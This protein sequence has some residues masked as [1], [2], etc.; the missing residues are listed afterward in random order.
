MGCQN[1]LLVWGVCPG[2]GLGTVSRQLPRP[3]A[4]VLQRPWVNRSAYRAQARPLCIL[5]KVAEGQSMD[6]E[7]LKQRKGCL[8]SSMSSFSNRSSILGFPHSQLWW[9]LSLTTSKTLLLPHTSG[10]PHS[11]CSPTLCQSIPLPPPE[12]AIPSFSASIS[13]YHSKPDSR[14]GR[15]NS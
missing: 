4:L 14:L 7:D 2:K 6:M 10:V 11:F 15:H 8:F 3:W 12:A 5:V 1:R 9:P 13:N